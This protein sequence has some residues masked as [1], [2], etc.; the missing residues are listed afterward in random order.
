VSTPALA[1]FLHEMG[2]FY[3]RRISLEQV[4]ARLG[5]SASGGERLALYPEFVRRQRRSLLDNFF[6]AARA[7]ARIE[8][9]GQWE[10][11][12]EGFIRAESP[13]HWDPN[14]YA[15]QMVAYL[16]QPHATAAKDLSVLIEL[17][18]YAW[19]RYQAMM[20]PHDATIGLDVALFVRQYT[21]DVVTYSEVAERSNAPSTAKPCTKS[22]TV[23]VARSRL[24]HKLEVVHL[25]LAALVALRRAI[26]PLVDSALPTGIAESDVAAEALALAA[27]GVIPALVA[28]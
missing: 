20:A 10:E 18:D 9:A 22:C 2:L 25:S 24:N 13:L 21:H 15:G 8:H 16:Q 6:S 14:R 26:D 4:T 7:A 3:E 19:I 12:V 1:T 28:P 17:A 27:L 11:L 5:A 23:L